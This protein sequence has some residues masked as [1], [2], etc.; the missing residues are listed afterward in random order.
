[1]AILAIPHSNAGCEIIFSMVRKNKT[2]Q[3][4]SMSSETPNALMVLKSRAKSR[5]AE[6]SNEQLKKFKAA[7]A[8]S[9]NNAL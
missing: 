2:D 8:K 5:D 4:A 6:F 7:Y 1:M 3:R 9:L